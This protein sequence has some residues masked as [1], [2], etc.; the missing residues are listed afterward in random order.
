MPLSFKIS[1]SMCGCLVVCECVYSC[2][3]LSVCETMLFR[4]CL[5]FVYTVLRDSLNSCSPNSSSAR[6]VGWYQRAP[7]FILHFSDSM[8]TPYTKNTGPSLEN[9]SLR[10]EKLC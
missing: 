10:Q 1:T 7:N 4:I 5:V 6:E 8:Y 3:C 2:Q 9:G